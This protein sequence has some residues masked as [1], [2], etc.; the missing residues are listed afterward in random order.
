MTEGQRNPKNTF[1]RHPVRWA[2]GGCISLLIAS[3]VVV[4]ALGM[5]DF[6]VYDADATIGYIPAASQHGSFLNKND[7][8]VN[9]LHM[10]AGRFAPSPKGNVLLVGDSIVW[11]GNPYAAHERL[12]AQIQARIEPAVW[13]IAAGSWALQNEL[14]YLNLHPEVVKQVD[15]IVIV[16]NS[17]DFDRPSSWACNL[18]HP[19]ARPLLALDYLARKYVLKQECPS[20]SPP[21]LRVQPK[22]PW[23]M[24]TAFAQAHPDKPLTFFLY[25]DKPEC[26]SPVLRQSRLEVFKARL[27]EHGAGQVISVGD[28]TEWQSCSHFYR[29]EIHPTPQGFERLATLVANAVESGQ[30]ARRPN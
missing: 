8:Q 19:R 4:R 29:D 21:E 28:A 9:E 18:T 26:E 3:E 1:R 16:S 24:L 13:P 30:A 6:P 25:P 14:T 2:A 11:G 23:A 15:R 5:V 27:L 12:G 20:E 22:D 7:W 10:T 17:G